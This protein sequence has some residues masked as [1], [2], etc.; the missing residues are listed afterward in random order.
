M[1]SGIVEETGKVVKIEK[2]QGNFHFFL[3]CSFADKL[4]VDQSSCTQWR[5][6]YSC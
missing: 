5:L 2:D 3:T 1:F 4:K 6:S